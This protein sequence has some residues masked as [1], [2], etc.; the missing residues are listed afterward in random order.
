VFCIVVRGACADSTAAAFRL[1]EAWDSGAHSW[2]AATLRAFANDLDEPR[3]LIAVTAS[4]NRSKSDRDPAEWLPSNASYRCAY[5]ADW[6]VVKHRWR[7]AVDT[8]ERA[9]LQR[10]IGGCGTLTVDAGAHVTPG[11]APP[12]AP[13]PEPEPAPAP[14][15]APAPETGGQPIVTFPNCD[16]MRAVY[17]DG[18]AREGTI[19]NVVSG[20]LRPFTGTPVFD[21]PLY[22]ANTA[23]DR[24]R[25][26]IAC[27]R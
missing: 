23:R 10:V 27:E 24:D 3:A 21:T 1:A 12:P 22:E 11:T 5:V 14:T 2:D 25:D 4:S 8:A 16:A 20:E 13:A 26:G 19:G 6:V 18:V 17:P 15:P 7:L 9:A